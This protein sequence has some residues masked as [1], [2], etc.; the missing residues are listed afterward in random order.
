M[1]AW[2][3]S[4][5]PRELNLLIAGTIAVA[6]LILYQFVWVPLQTDTENLKRKVSHQQELV[7]WMK[8]AEKTITSR[9]TQVEQTRIT[10]LNRSLLSVVDKSTRNFKLV[11]VVK[12]IEPDG[13][14]KVRVW[15]EKAD[16]DNMTRWLIT[17]IKSYAV[18]VDSINVDQGKS[19]GVI[20][21]RLVL[22]R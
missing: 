4:L 1:K 10:G 9:N 2:L 8:K 11:K 12:R 14:N 17:L 20:N 13:D 22:I 5:E 6:V 7:S 18:S 15:L 21:A 16:F 19:S 3:E